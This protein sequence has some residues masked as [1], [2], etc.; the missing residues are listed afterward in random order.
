MGEDSF[1]T[2]KQCDSK[3]S[4]VY[5]KMNAIDRK[6]ATI[7]GGVAVLVFLSTFMVGMV[8]FHIN[9]RFSGMEKTLEKVDTRLL[10]Y[11]TK[12]PGQ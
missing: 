3:I 1:I 10:D 12:K 7:M 6:V 9:T 5:E 4:G 11:V 2:E 8:S